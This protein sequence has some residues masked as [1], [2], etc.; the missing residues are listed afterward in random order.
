M[1]FTVHLQPLEKDFTVPLLSTKQPRSLH[2]ILIGMDPRP[3]PP[4]ML[5]ANEMVE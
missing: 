1:A 5:S 4:T 2:P 3:T